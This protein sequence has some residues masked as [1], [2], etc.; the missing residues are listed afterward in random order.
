MVDEQEVDSTSM[1]VEM[2]SLATSQMGNN[3]QPAIREAPPLIQEN[4]KKPE[5]EQGQDQSG[6]GGGDQL[7][8][9]HTISS[10]LREPSADPKE[11]STDT[12]MERLKNP[13]PKEKEKETK[14]EL[15]FSQADL[16][17]EFETKK[18]PIEVRDMDSMEISFN[19]QIKDDESDNK[20]KNAKLGEK[21]IFE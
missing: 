15:K 13:E 12:L 9:K 1:R 21:E 20:N 6:G 10:N 16:E 3:M 7:K 2:R 5:Q 8:P 18:K 4:V 17:D 14:K 11:P 19:V